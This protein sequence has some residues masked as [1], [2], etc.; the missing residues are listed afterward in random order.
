MSGTHALGEPADP[1]PRPRPEHAVI[2]G[3]SL[4]L[5]PLAARHADELW[6]VARD[7]P[8]SWMWLPLGPFADRAAFAG[9]LRFMAVSKAEL[10]WVVRPH[11]PDG[12]PG[13]AAGWLALL[14]IRPADAAIELGNIWFPP[15]LARTR[16]ATE[17][18][19]LLLDHAF[20]LGYRRMAWKCNTRNTASC[21]AAERLG[22][23]FEGVLRAH[24]VVRA[25]RRDTAYYSMLDSEWPERRAALAH[26][27]RDANFG[28]DGRAIESLQ[29]HEDSDA[30]S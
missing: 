12:E 26:W 7:A 28:A 16:A 22:F 25:H 24:M 29:R 18:M 9:Y 20:R 11:G 14:D 4:T 3:A 10:V 23:R 17:A 19:F 6:E 5:E 15:G 8:D 1:T 30:R 2:R 13:P 21:R 27:L